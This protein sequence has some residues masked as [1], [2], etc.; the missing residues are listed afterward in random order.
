MLRQSKFVRQSA[1]FEKI[2]SDAAQEPI[3]RKLILHEIQS[4]QHIRVSDQVEHKG[5]WLVNET[6]MT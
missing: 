5:H 6:P 3:R 2:A 4:V 1:E